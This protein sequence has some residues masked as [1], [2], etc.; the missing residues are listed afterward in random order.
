MDVTTTKTEIGKPVNGVTN[1]W[2]ASLQSREI[3]SVT[4]PVSFASSYCAAR[5]LNRGKSIRLYTLRFNGVATIP[6]FPGKLVNLARKQKR[7]MRKMQERRSECKNS[8]KSWQRYRK[9]SRNF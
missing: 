1:G 3:R 5:N 4:L 2:S 6:T 7:A 9:A 8:S